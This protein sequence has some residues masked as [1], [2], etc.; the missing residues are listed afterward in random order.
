[1]PGEGLFELPNVSM[2]TD[3]GEDDEVKGHGGV[4]HVT[5]SG[6]GEM[7]VEEVLYLSPSK[8]AKLMAGLGIVPSSQIKRNEGGRGKE[9]FRAKKS[10]AATSTPTGTC[11]CMCAMYIVGL[12]V[13]WF[14][15]GP[16]PSGWTIGVNV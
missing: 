4:G 2:E 5:N 12:C 8:R 10:S 15:D 7:E 6:C 1:M 16:L 9:R 11:T 3:G 13:C 14:S